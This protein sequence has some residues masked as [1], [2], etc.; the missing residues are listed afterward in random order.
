VEALLPDVTA[1]DSFTVFVGE[2]EADLRRAL[3]AGFGSEVGREAVAEALAYGWEHWER[4]GA[5]ENPAGYLFR[6]AQRK[7][8]RMTSRG[9]NL[10]FEEAVSSEAWF[11]PGFEPAWASLSDR[12]RVVVGLLHAFDWSLGEVAALLG[13]SRSSVQSY[14]QRGLTKLR[15]A[16]GVRS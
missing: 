2:R 13:V 11:E 10:G 7:A 1:S 6:V 15:R 4:V 5:T 8:R 3:T 16:L 12:Q 9:I 14:E